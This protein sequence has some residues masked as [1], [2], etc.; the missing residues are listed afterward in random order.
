MS[1]W[2]TE[3]LFAGSLRFLSL[4]KVSEGN[5]YISYLIRKLRSNSLH[6]YTNIHKQ[7]KTQTPLTCEVAFVFV[8]PLLFSLAPFLIWEPVSCSTP[9]LEFFPMSA[10]TSN[11]SWQAQKSPLRIPIPNNYSISYT[12]TDLFPALRLI[13]RSLWPVNNAVD[14]LINFP[15]VGTGLNI[16]MLT[17]V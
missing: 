15:L 2:K 3:G 12:P 14:L 5:G 9:A 16:V 1:R 6:T 11:T 10:H 13:K 8:F 7:L 17:Y 4:S